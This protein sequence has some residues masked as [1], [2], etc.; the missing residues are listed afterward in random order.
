MPPSKLTLS[1]R[2]LSSN[3]SGISAHRDAAHGGVH[4]DKLSD[5]LIFVFHLRISFEIDL[6]DSFLRSL[7]LNPLVIH[8]RLEIGG[9]LVNHQ[10]SVIRFLQGLINEFLRPGALL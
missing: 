10:N 9:A 1:T 3:S 7:P 4:H 6:S 2:G 5:H 8:A